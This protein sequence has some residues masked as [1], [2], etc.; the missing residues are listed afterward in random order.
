MRQK[1][2]ATHAHKLREEHKK[3]HNG[4]TTQTLARISN[5]K[6]SSVIAVSWCLKMFKGS[7]VSKDVQRMLGVVLHVPR[8]PFYSPKR[9]RSRWSSIW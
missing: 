6:S 8:G 3:Q 5:Y 2:T 4:I 7:L 9:P 1:I